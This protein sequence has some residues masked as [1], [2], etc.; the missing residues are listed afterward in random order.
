MKL[1]VDEDSQARRLLDALRQAGHDVLSVAEL[2]CNGLPDA[3]VFAQAQS[4]GRTLLTH[5]VADFL[6][7]ARQAGGH[8]GVLAVFRDGNPRHTMDYGHIVRAIDAL[9]A[10]GLPVQGQFH[11]L[12]HWR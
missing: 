5:N 6:A 1:L 11:I 10:A 7:L 3:Q 9:Q 4:Q 12:N 2:G 8:A